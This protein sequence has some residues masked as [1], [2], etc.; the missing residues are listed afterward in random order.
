[1]RTRVVSPLL[2]TGVLV[3]SLAGPATAA[4]ISGSPGPD[5]LLGTPRADTIRGFAGND[6]LRGRRGVDHL[7]GGHGADRLFP[8][9]DSRTDVLRGG[10]GPD[11]IDARVGPR[12]QGPDSVNAGAGNDTVRAVEVWGWAVPQVDCGPGEDTYVVPYRFIPSMGCEHVVL[13]D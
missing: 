11:R 1:M 7:Y 8:G 5:V 10:P 9:D 6:I 4:V 12:G 2:I 3:A 13:F